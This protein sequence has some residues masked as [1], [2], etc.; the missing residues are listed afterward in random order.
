MNRDTELNLVRTCRERATRSPAEANEG[1]DEFAVEVA[2]Y[3]TPERFAEERSA[4]FRSTP[5]VV[6]H[7][8]ELRGPGDFVTRELAGVPVVVTRDGNGALHAMINVCRHRGARVALAPRGS[9]K[10]LV[11]PYH[12]WTYGL[13][14]RLERIRHREGFAS[15]PL[16]DHGLRSLPVIE[17]AGLVWVRPDSSA[18]PDAPP[19]I[20]EALAS[21]IDATDIGALEPFETTT[22]EWHAN[23]KLIVDGGLEAYHFKIAHQRTV[24]P[25]FLDTV[26]TF[27]F[28]GPHIRTV[29]PRTTL[30]KLADLSEERWH[31]R[32][33]ANVLYSLYPNASL[34]VQP[35]HVV[36]I[37]ITPLAVDRTRIEVT[38]LVPPGWREDEKAQRYWK[39][40]HAITT[41]TLDEDF[42][43][44]EQIQAGARSGA[45][46]AWHFA[47]YEHALSQWHRMIDQR[48]S[49]AARAPV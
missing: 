4:I 28:L 39:M 29:L 11:C 45:N 26:A 25:F 19:P 18:A 41:T 21:E 31:L 37:L 38:S 10:K 8:S 1:H 2:K 13:D 42:V 22:R 48:L 35:D 33:H 9:C 49:S 34:L 7:G 40:N 12:A 36:L 5:N 30:P 47:S 3:V 15:L 32:Q 23:W 46:D 24:A 6:A 43:I 44:A 27:D 17:R 16:E 20:S 14:G